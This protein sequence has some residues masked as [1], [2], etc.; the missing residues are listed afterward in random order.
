MR[1]IKDGYEGSIEFFLTRFFTLLLFFLFFAFLA[2]SS[3]SK[4]FESVSKNSLYD[5][6]YSL[7]N[8]VFAAAFIAL[9]LSIKKRQL[10][11]AFFWIFQFI[12]FGIGGLMTQ[13][14]PFPYYLAR[15]STS[16]NLE[17][18]SQITLIAQLATGI[19]QIFVLINR[20]KYSSVI[21]DDFSMD[22]NYVL[23]R[24]KYFLVVYVFVCPFLINGLGGVE[25]LFRRVRLSNENQFQAISIN[26][27]FQTLLYVPPLIFLVVLLYFR[28]DHRIH[29][30]TF[31][32]LGFWVILLSNPFANARQLTLFLTLPLL[33]ILLQNRVK[34]TL[35]FFTGLPFLFLFSAGLINRYT[36]QLQSPRLTIISRDG[37]FDSF[38]QVANGLEVISQGGFPILKQIFGPVLFFV[39][40]S[41][42][43]DKPSDT[44]VELAR[45][46][47]L[48]FQ[49]L[50]APWI[51][52][53]Y[54]NARLPGVILIGLIIGM[55]L[56]KIDLKSTLDLKG[57]L[58]SVLTSGFLFIL[59]RGSLLQ[60][61]GRVIF[62]YFLIFLI[63][64][65]SKNY[66]TP[67]S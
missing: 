48:R 65:K 47:G 3:M 19:A 32:I 28:G 58:L 63:L 34:L 45:F 6:K 50:S 60:A 57:Y 40:R 9:S 33:F 46:L 66:S 4:S 17:R 67:I 2:V 43:P 7:L 54:A 30:K 44:G 10:N 42:L 36:G 53:A 26:A 64:R 35:L 5:A 8:L 39:P 59:L 29:K 13:L 24:V 41:F 16:A 49:N 27:I 37:D 20:K 21:Q 56:T 52:E 23:K 11:M 55:I 15:I 31:T 12:F 22:I 1:S 25:Y 14:D 18:T 61:T 51:L 38:S 62:T